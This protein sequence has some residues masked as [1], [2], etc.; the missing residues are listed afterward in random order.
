MRD[1]GRA[2]RTASPNG[3][4]PTFPTVHRPKVKWCS[5]RGVYA[6]F[7]A[8]VVIAFV[9]RRDGEATG[10]VLHVAEDSSGFVTPF[11]ALRAGSESE[12]GHLATAIMH[13]RAPLAYSPRQAKP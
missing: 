13:A 12:G 8:V 2:A 11:A 10:A 3:S 4:R 1:A 7:A 9:W 6:S 5:G